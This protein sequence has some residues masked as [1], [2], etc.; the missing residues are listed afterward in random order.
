MYKLFCIQTFAPVCLIKH[1]NWSSV[2]V[3]NVKQCV[4]KTLMLA[5]LCFTVSEG[6]NLT[7][8]H[9]YPDFRF[10]IY[11]PLAFR[12]FR[13]LFGIKPDDY[14]VRFYQTWDQL[15]LCD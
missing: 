2:N 15:Y 13:E 9:H 6:S 11:A 14:L 3:F 7:P 10:K 5:L 8:G 4:S 12:Y 1:N